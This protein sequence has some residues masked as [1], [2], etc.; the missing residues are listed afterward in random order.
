M[1]IYFPPHYTRRK[2]TGTSTPPPNVLYDIEIFLSRP[3]L[4]KQFVNL[5]IELAQQNPLEKLRGLGVEENPRAHPPIWAGRIQSGSIPRRY[6]GQ[7]LRNHCRC[8]SPK[9]RGCHYMFIPFIHLKP[10]STIPF[11]PRKYHQPKPELSNQNRQH[12][13]QTPATLNPQ[14]QWP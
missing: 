5:R 13:T 2:S 6:S 11:T 1:C 14:P 4:C 12:N 3:F 10:E 8:C 7:P 9:T